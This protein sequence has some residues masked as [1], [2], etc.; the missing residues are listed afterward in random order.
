MLKRLL[1]LALLASAASC[2]AQDIKYEKFQLKNG[3]TVILHEDHSLPTVAVNLWYHVGSKDEPPHRT[4][5]AHL[6]EHLMFMGTARVPNGK[7]DSVMEAGG[8]SNNASTAEDRTNYFETGPSALLPTFL[9]LEADRMEALGKNIDQKKLDLQREVVKNELRQSYENQ[10]YGPAYLMIDPLIY[11][12]G[13]PYHI[14]VIGLHEDLDAATV[15]DV[16]SFFSTFYVPNDAT[17][18][19]AGDFDTK[20]VKPQIEKLFG[21]LPR[22]TDPI[23]REAAPAKLNEVKRITVVDEHVQ[24]P[25]IIMVWHSPAAYTPGDIQMTLAGSVLGDGVAGKLYQRLVAEKD[26]ATEVSASQNSLLLG[27]QFN[28][29]V[30]AKPDADL[31]KV[32]AETDEVLSE[33]VRT[34]PTEEDLKRQA[35]KIE[36]GVLSGLQSPDNIADRLNEFE[37]YFGEPNSF[38]K[39]LD[40]FRTATSS[41]V[42]DRAKSVLNPN[43]RLIMRV[44][45][46]PVAAASGDPRATQPAM[47]SESAFKLPSPTTFKL[48]N[49]VQVF[50]WQR[51]ELPLMNVSMLFRGGAALDPPAKAGASSIAAEMLSQ[52]TGNLS[53]EGF[54]NALSLLGGNFSAGAGRLRSSA[55]LTVLAANFDKALGLYTEALERPKFAKEDWDRVQ[56][57]MVAELGRSEETP[58]TISTNIASEKLYG[59][60]TP[61]GTPSAGHPDTVKALSVDDAKAAYSRIFHPDGAVL[62]VAGSL[63][64]AAVKDQLEKTIG[65]WKPTGVE[66]AL[67]TSA[68]F[69][70]S[71]ALRVYIFDK[72]QAVQTVVRFQFPSTKYSDPNRLKLNALSTLFGGTFTSRLNHNLREEKGYTYGAGSRFTL[73]PITG[74][75]TASSDVRADVT[76][77][78]L[79]EF[80]SEINKI[81]GGDITDAEAVKA[82]STMR[83][84]TVQALQGLGGLIGTASGLYVNG[85]PF[86]TL[87]QDLA[88][89]AAIR[90][91]DINAIVHNAIDFDH[92]VLVLVGDK[93]LILKQISGLGL[94]TPE[95]LK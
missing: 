66:T 1:S 53:A 12:E 84:E 5:F 51:P 17:M 30:T 10:P 38:K 2:F 88:A 20:S 59:K 16:Q 73:D 81:R 69:V 46:Q 90:A 85:L 68:P 43:A 8:G 61:Y 4:G 24:Q 13:H 80:L 27:S 67:P 3:L 58:R 25:K 42:R 31:S 77:P 35:A 78:A 92:G 34:G 95:V 50:F 26:L 62:F 65:A 23:H 7:F 87:N 75:F 48:S 56:K 89:T 32:E 49:G 18:A 52:G 60:D 22:Q 93:G 44:I 39:V 83:S 74:T 28:V 64:E 72:P 54:E 14:P 76:G 9:W 33:F 45:P 79:K 21:S 41:E 6:F 29:E 63:S 71:T 91:A 70:P 94:P 15:K 11:P 57:T 86:E 47:G 36:V 82:T 40:M 19:I 55:G 37:F